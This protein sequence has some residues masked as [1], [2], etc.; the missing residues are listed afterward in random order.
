MP[1]ISTAQGKLFYE[2]QGKGEPVV[3][4]RG[5]SFS[6]RHWLGFDKK[7][8]QYYKVITF[9]NRGVGRSQAKLDW[10]YSMRLL[11]DDICQILDA[12]GVDDAHFMGFSLGGMMSLSTALLRPD[13]TKS[14]TL[15]NSSVGGMLVPRLAPA[16]LY[17]SIRYGLDQDRLVGEL[18]KVLVFK[19]TDEWS[20]E[21]IADEFK[22]IYRQEGF[23][24]FATAMQLWAAARFLVTDDLKKLKTPTLIVYGA[25]DIFV[26]PINSL[27]LH[28]VIPHAKLLKI[29]E[30]G[31]E[32]MLDKPNELIDE[33]GMFLKS[34]GK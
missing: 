8:A 4:I 31:H 19:G 3:I 32:L 6:S 12:V 16:A 18:A 22:K 26:P 28:K 30:A 33:Y 34:L 5:M 13:R 1:T 15:V 24:T 25:N 27:K 9:D 20:K 7:L 2:V 11:T 10:R 17:T 14:I 23:P 21:K 29:E